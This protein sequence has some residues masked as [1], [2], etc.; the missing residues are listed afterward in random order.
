MLLEDACPHSEVVTLSRGR[1]QG[2]WLECGYHGLTFDALGQCRRAPGSDRIPRGARVRAY[3][4]I[5]RYAMIWIWMGD[6]QLADPAK[7][8]PIPEWSDPVWGRNSGDTMDVECH[9]LYVTDSLLDPSHVAW[10]HQS[11]I[12]D[13]GIRKCARRY[14]RQ[15]QRQWPGRERAGRAMWKCRLSTVSS[16]DFPGDAIGCSTTR[17]VTPATRS[18]RQCSSRAALEVRRRNPTR[19]R[20]S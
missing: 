13:S 9:Y 1:I 5:S 2:D 12:A 8:F 4:V 15:C 14:S 6:P 17:C 19:R 16:P 7:I 3:P 10:V 20:S 18:S 11:S